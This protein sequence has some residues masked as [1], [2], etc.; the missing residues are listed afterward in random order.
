MR[1]DAVGSDVRREV[2]RPRSDGMAGVF[3]T[4]HSAL[5]DLDPEP[6]VPQAPG[7]ALGVLPVAEGAAVLPAV[8]ALDEHLELAA[9]EVAP[10]STGCPIVTRVAVPGF[11]S[12]LRT[13][14]TS[15]RTSVTPLGFGP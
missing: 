2:T 7:R 3:R 14:T 9:V 13:R 12:P 10:Y 8:P 1:D 6:F 4:D 15:T 5:L 11:R